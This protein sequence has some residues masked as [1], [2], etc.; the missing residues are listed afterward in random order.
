M[1]EVVTSYCLAGVEVLVQVQ[2]LPVALARLPSQPQAV[3]LMPQQASLLGPL[4]V[5]LALHVQWVGLGQQVAGE[6]GVPSW[7]PQ[8]LRAGQQGLPV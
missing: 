5:H 2:V 1:V 3:V 4:S 8:L 6:V 7:P